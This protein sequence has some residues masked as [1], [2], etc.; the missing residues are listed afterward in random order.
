MTSLHSASLPARPTALVEADGAVALERRHPYER[1]FQRARE[2][3]AQAAELRAAR[4]W[5]HPRE[6]LG[7]GVLRLAHLGGRDARQVDVLEG[8]RELVHQRA[9]VPESGERSSRIG[10]CPELGRLRP[11]DD[12]GGRV[13]RRSLDEEHGAARRVVGVHLGREVVGK[14]A[15]PRLDRCPGTGLDARVDLDVLEAERL[16]RPGPVER[17][18]WDQ[19]RHRIDQRAAGADPR[20][21]H[22]QLPGVEAEE[23]QRDGGDLLR[24]W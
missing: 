11:G 22:L 4:W 16:V 6:L 18:R 3:Q 2:L 23:P 10:G 24:R 21:Q 20:R 5:V 1:G 9:D 14:V 12:A 8:G 7:S 13:R 15:H 17:Q 19:P